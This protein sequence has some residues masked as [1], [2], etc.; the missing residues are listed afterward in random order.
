LNPA[1]TL[2]ADL[3]QPRSADILQRFCRARDGVI[4]LAL[5]PAYFDLLE[6][7]GN[8]HKKLPPVIHV[9]GT[10]G[11][12]STC[13][14]LRA[15]L[16]ADGR[17]VHVYTSP[18]LVTFHERIRVAGQLIGEDELVDLFRDI[19]RLA[20]PGK[21][22]DFE[23]ATAAAFT[24]FSRHPADAVILEVGLGGRLDATNVI[25]RPAVSAIARLSYDHCKFLGNTLTEIAREKAGIMRQGVDCFAARQPD[26][27]SVT[28]LRAAAIETGARLHLGGVDWSIEPAPTGFRFSAANATITLPHPS[29]LGAHQMENAGLAIAALS[30]LPFAVRKEAIARG[31]QQ[32]EWPARLQKLSQGRLADK[33]PPG[34]E[35]WLDGG[36]NDSAGEVL[37]HQM[38][39]W[40]DENP[41]QPLD[42]VFGM[43]TTKSP[44]DFL[45]PLAPF[46]RTARTMAIPDET[47]GF[48]AEALANE[49]RASGISSAQA[50]TDINAALRE[51]TV[52]Q[53]PGRILICGSLY[54]AG[55]I[56]RAN[57]A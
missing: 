13:A 44:G 32:A 56:L 35:L 25:E 1:L 3:A 18:H 10:N 4:R 54:L 36:H 43:L 28:A 22:S 19:E 52:A 33:L 45:R 57:G 12:G 30:G 8:P 42:V 53:V 27:E 48:S 55:H 26:A 51:L 50:S 23:V 11:K 14:F 6:K 15:M 47:L 49:T 31:V 37:A 17:R 16:E 2:P 9:A 20:K 40:R 39:A 7:L 41:A 34:W 38:R 21:V 5:E 46:I 29:L 24:A